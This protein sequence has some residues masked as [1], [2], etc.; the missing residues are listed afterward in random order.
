M[1]GAPFAISALL[2]TALI[3]CQA[4]GGGPSKPAVVVNSPPS[5]TVVSEGDSVEVNSTSTDAKGIT[6]VELQVDGVTARTDTSPVA[7]G[8]PQFTLVQIWKATG[9]GN[10]TLIV[11]AYN[12]SGAFTEAGLSIVVNQVAAASLTETPTVTI[13]TIVLPPTSAPVATLPPA[14]APPTSVPTAATLAPTACTPNSLYV[15]DITI[16]DGTLVQ[17]GLTFVKTWLVRNTGTCAWDSTYSIAFAAGTPFVSGS[18][19]IPA[20]APGAQVN[21]SLTMTAPTGP[22][23]YV[24]TWRLRGPDG[25]LFG[26]N[27]TTAINVPSPNPPSPTA[28][29]TPLPGAPAI[30][31]FTCTPCTIVA[32]SSATLNWGAVTNAT[33]VSIDQ[34]IG[35]VATPGHKSVSPS[36]NTTYTLTATGPGGTSQASVTVVVAANFGGHW[37]HD[38][39]IMDLSQSGANVTGTFHN[40]AE[41]G[42]GT[43]AGTVNGNTLTGTWQR[44]V[45]GTLQFTL[46]GGGN[47]FT[48]NWNGSFQWCGART[49]VSFPSGCAFDGHWNTKYDPG[50]GTMCL[51]DLSQVGANVSGTYCNGT[52]TGGTI[53]YSAGY[54]ILT[55]TWNFGTI[56]SGPFKFWLPLYT[57]QQ[58]QGNYN[59]SLDWCG[60]RNGSSMPSPCEKN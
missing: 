46:G 5:G 56:N 58:F 35:G 7:A 11:R 37:D 20:A 4:V 54:V 18:A 57:S 38:F 52:I 8:Q 31:S 24:G 12:T 44:G 3:G 14:T 33:N 53:T 59:G 32:G 19:P 2:L 55:G 45:P 47:T 13:P 34:G 39:G 15:A 36:T 48:G 29:K 41:V 28:T 16:P 49:G 22:G 27:L 23:S 50:T 21:I 51:M 26:T 1:R 60:W 25:A 17:P 40:S 43:I 30:S 10:H 9:P 42:D 6:R